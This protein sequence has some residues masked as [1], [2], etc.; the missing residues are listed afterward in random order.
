LVAQLLLTWTA[1]PFLIVSQWLTIKW[2]LPARLAFNILML[3]LA[4]LVLV[5]EGRRLR[6]FRREAYIAAGTLLVIVASVT[7]NRVPA[8]VALEGAVPYVVVLV[9]VL[10]GV[11]STMR[12]HDI[13]IGA[14]VGAGGVALMGF[15]A[16]VQLVSGRPGYVW[17]AQDLPYPRWWER[18]RATGLVVNPA[19]LG[20][21]GLVALS[22]SPVVPG[23]WAAVAASVTIAASGSR[24]AMIGTLAI[25]LMWPFFRGSSAL[26]SLWTGSLGALV[27]FAVI[28]IA[29][30]A[31]RD[32]LS[33]RTALVVEE[34]QGETAT[35]DIR[36]AN[37]R[38]SL[39]AWRAFPIVGTGPGRFGSTTA[40]E[41]RSPLHER[42]GLPDVRSEEYLAELRAQ[43]DLREIDV[44]TAQLDLGWFQILAEL[45]A[46]GL[47]GFAALLVSLAVR[48]WTARRAVPLALL[49]T[50]V[51][52]SFGS[53]GLV[54]VSLSSVMLWWAGATLVVP[55]GLRIGSSDEGSA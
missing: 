29:L 50:L 41:N 8:R 26:R 25:L 7:I 21:L 35:A 43:A 10:A 13:W 6:S 31:A 15:A 2:N 19:R 38:A 12:P 22:L 11:V 3:G 52:L 51:V 36:V 55:Q 47:A 45:G 42:F 17:T 1:V 23:V 33:S 4:G 16:V 32:D 30:P 49:L 24:I 53:P 54:D 27:L 20:Q 9:V 18:G 39:R 44:G 40:W 5:V 28:Q 48:A 14:T 34:I 46:A 37:V